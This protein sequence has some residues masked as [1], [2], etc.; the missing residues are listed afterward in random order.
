VGDSAEAFLKVWLEIMSEISE[1]DDWYLR[2]LDLDQVIDNGKTLET[3]KSTSIVISD[4]GLK[5][6]QPLSLIR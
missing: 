3:M 6:Q 5:R 2:V 1:M 4:D